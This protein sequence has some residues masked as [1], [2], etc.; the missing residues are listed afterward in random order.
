MQISANGSPFSAEIAWW[1]AM[2]QRG[3]ARMRKENDGRAMPSYSPRVCRV[4]EKFK[5]AVRQSVE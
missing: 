3:I 4:G 1:D 5:P 2:R